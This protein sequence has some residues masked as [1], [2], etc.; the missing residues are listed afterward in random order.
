MGLLLDLG[1]ELISD[2]T[3]AVEDTVETVGSLLHPS[4][5]QDVDVPA[6]LVPQ[7]TAP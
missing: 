2:V 5:I 6:G 1:E 3:G 7:S 4:S